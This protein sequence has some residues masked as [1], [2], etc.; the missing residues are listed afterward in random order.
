ML[1]NRI[2]GVVGIRK[3]LMMLARMAI[4]DS[5][6]CKDID[7]AMHHIFMHTPFHKVTGDCHRDNG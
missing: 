6:Q 1:F 2:N 3:V 7:L 5:T 4:I